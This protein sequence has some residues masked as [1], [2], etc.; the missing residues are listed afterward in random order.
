MCIEEGNMFE[1]S[2]I[3][4]LK[5]EVTGNLIKEIIA[6]GNTDGGTIIVGVNDEGTIRGIADINNEMNKITNLVR[7]AI[8]P[9][10]TMFTSV[11][12]EEHESM[13]ARK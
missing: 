8:K 10:L 9:D 6:F 13:R 12:I 3:L 7:D 5:R 11:K 1:E 2:E 4:E